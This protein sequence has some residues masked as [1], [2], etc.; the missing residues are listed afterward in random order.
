MFV[1][2]LSSLFPFSRLQYIAN[3]SFE[4]GWTSV[5]RPSLPHTISVALKGLE[6]VCLNVPERNVACEGVLVTPVGTK[7]E[8]KSCFICGVLGAHCFG[9]V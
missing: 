2:P 8:F 9:V 7:V 6:W 1:Y 5:L 3:L 4:G